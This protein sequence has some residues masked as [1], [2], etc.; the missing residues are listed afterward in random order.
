MLAG[1]DMVA[2]GAVGK[3][4]A[5]TGQPV[6]A[7][8][9]RH[10]QRL[11]GD[12]GGAAAQKFRDRVGP[13]IL[14]RRGHIQL[15]RGD[16][17]QQVVLVKGQLGFPAHIL[18][19]VGA[20]KV[21]EGV[22]DILQLFTGF[23]PGQRAAQGAWLV[24]QHGKKPGVQPAGQQRGLCQTG[25]ARHGHPTG[26]HLRQGPYMIQHPHGRPGPQN[27]LAGGVGQGAVHLQRA[28]QAVV[29]VAV[30]RGDVQ[31]AEGGH[32]P[33]PVGELLHRQVLVGHIG[34][35]ADEDHQRAG[36]V[37]RGHRQRHRKGEL[38][39]GQRHR[40]PEL[41]QRGV[42]GAKTLVHRYLPHRE[43]LGGRRQ[44]AIGF[45][46]KEL[47]QLHVAPPPAGGRGGEVDSRQGPGFQHI[48]Q[49]H[50]KAS[51]LRVSWI[52]DPS[53]TVFTVL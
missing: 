29:K 34:T 23:S 10:A 2:Q 35:E 6:G 8:Q 12:V 11:P 52:R 25:M 51:K 43:L 31:V 33:A 27:Q 24:G 15:P 37:G 49:G 46:A 53:Q 44:M 41:A 45:P 9:P 1:A 38:P 14:G 22:A 21:G 40:Q 3:G 50:G 7:Q 16:E 47:L 20:E 17:G 4:L 13:Q 42:S 18:P 19:Q 32:R 36:P 5:Q 30:V 39:P 26:V 28:G 48:L